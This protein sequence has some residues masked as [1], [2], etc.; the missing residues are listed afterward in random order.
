MGM[1]Q[2]QGE[3]SA[4]FGYWRSTP[5]ESRKQLTVYRGR[6]ASLAAAA[7]REES[8]NLLF[9]LVNRVIGQLSKEIQ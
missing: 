4:V 9:A 3:N 8:R 5:F 6:P 2:E 7:L 1:T